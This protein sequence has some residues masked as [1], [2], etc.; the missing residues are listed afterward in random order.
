MRWG[1][2]QKPDFAALECVPVNR[3]LTERKFRQVLEFRRGSAVL[4]ATK[5]IAKRLL[6]GRTYNSLRDIVFRNSAGR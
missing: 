2:N 3:H 4:Y 6:P 5:Q 1:Y